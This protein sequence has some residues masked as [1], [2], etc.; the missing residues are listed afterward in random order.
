MYSANPT[1]WSLDINLLEGGKSTSTLKH[2]TYTF[3]IDWKAL[4]LRSKKKEP[5]PHFSLSNFYPLTLISL[6]CPHHMLHAVGAASAHLFNLISMQRI[7]LALKRFGFSSFV[8]FLFFVVAFVPC[9]DNQKQWKEEKSFKWWVMHKITIDSYFSYSLS[10]WSP[11]R[12]REVQMDSHST[13][14]TTA[15]KP[16]N[17]LN[18]DLDEF[19][20]LFF[21]SSMQEPH[22][23][24]NWR[25]AISWSVHKK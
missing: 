8:N 11:L 16:C 15:D 14:T 22:I 23:A 18:L 3:Y 10:K 6:L 1:T 9:V 13:T 4:R 24:V 20:L 7:R 17:H 5:S 12:P 19:L 21:T 2:R 25:T